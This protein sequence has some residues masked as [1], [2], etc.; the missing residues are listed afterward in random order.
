MLSRSNTFKSAR[1]KEKRRKI[2]IGKIA[3]TVFCLGSLWG[4]IFWLSNLPAVTIKDISVSGN[5]SVFSQDVVADAQKF[6]SG[7]YFFTV[8]KSSILLYPK[9]AIEKDL[10]DSF[11]RIASVAVSFKNFNT[12]G[13][14]VS[15]RAPEA[16]WCEL[17]TAPSDGAVGKGC[18]YI[19]SSGFIFAPYATSSAPAKFVEFYG[20]LTGTNPIGQTYHSADYL[21]NRLNF[22]GDLFSAGFSVTA[23]AERTG[24]VSEAKF[25][26]GQRLIFADDTDLSAAFSNFQSV[27]SNPDFKSSGN[28]EKLDYIDLRF[29]NK[30]FYK[31][32]L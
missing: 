26:S 5:V 12:I 15:E 22:A 1:L 30:V 6:L 10:R 19:D 25:S 14:K 27:V 7:R 2:I 3:V 4:L 16:L 13:I 31:L 20:P 29:G 32:K 9:S 11:P 23:F 17:L 18:F 8:P 24:G 21:Q 28:F